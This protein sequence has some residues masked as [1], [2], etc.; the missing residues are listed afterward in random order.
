[1]PGVVGP[2]PDPL[3]ALLL[4]YIGGDMT[5]LEEDVASNLSL[6]WPFADRTPLVLAR[7]SLTTL[8][9]CR[10]AD[11]TSL[12]AISIWLKSSSDA[13]CPASGTPLLKY[14]LTFSPDARTTRPQ[15][16]IKPSSQPPLY[17]QPLVCVIDPWPWN[18]SCFIVPS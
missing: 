4:L 14:C 5:T 6:P 13:S 3:M 1:M 11:T 12:T 9:C 2:E 15:P 8:V 7:D 18:L 17:F 10:I 16:C